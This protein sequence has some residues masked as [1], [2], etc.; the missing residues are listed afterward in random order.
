MST[1]FSICYWTFVALTS[2]FLFFGALLLWAVTA[3]FDPTRFL[4]REDHVDESI[5]RRVGSARSGN[6][7]ADYANTGVNSFAAGNSPRN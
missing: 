5:E 2:I 1:T 7:P 6:H 4:L 3:P